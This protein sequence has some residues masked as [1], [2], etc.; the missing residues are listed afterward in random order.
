LIPFNSHQKLPICRR[1]QRISETFNLEIMW[2]EL[3]VHSLLLSSTEIWN[4]LNFAYTS[5]LKFSTW[6]LCTEI[7]YF[8]SCKME[9]DIGNCIYKL[10]C[11]TTLFTK[12]LLI[13]IT[14]YS[15]IMGNETSNI[16]I[17]NFENNA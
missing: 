11:L 9:Y 13:Q 16:Q 14:F 12:F 3:E 7:F 2:P 15:V 17:E 1:D 4:G 5:L 10:D 8:V 6:Y